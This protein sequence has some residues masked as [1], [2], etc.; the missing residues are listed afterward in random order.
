MSPADKY[1]RLR[2]GQWRLAVQPGQWNEQLQE[3][4]LATAERQASAK[5][6]QT[7][8]LTCS[9]NATKRLYLKVFSL[10]LGFAALTNFL[11]R[12]K[13]ARFLNQGL[14]LQKA[15]FR[16]PVPIAIGEMRAWSLSQR[17]FVLTAEVDGQSLVSYLHD[18]W[19]GRKPR[20][21]PARKRAALQELA[22]MIRKFHDL[23][24]VH[25]DLVPSNL[26]VVDGPAGPEFYFMDNDRTRRYF[27]W[28]PQSL[29]RRN[30]V[31]LNRFALPGISLQDRVRFFLAYTGRADDQRDRRLLR[32]LERRTRKRRRECDGV[33]GGGSFRML[34]R[35]TPGTIGREPLA[36]GRKMFGK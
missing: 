13:A 12:S 11:R 10:P 22:A 28:L 3:K 6:P 34:M 32:W 21:A 7:F 16:A 15:G 26:F 27:P 25:G 31:Q 1:E 23:G 17:A 8:P 33:D 5:H 4:I 18:C 36:A 24:F 29:W 14:A 19:S 35:W 20:P 30:L 2:V 9:V